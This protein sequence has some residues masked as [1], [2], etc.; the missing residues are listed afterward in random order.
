MNLSKKI[1]VAFGIGIA[2]VAAASGALTVKKGTLVTI[3]ATIDV[4]A[5]P[6]KV[7]SAITSLDGFAALTGFKA[8]GGAAFRK[9]GD[10]APA[11]AW[12]DKGRLVVTELVPEKELRVSF[13]PAQ[14]HYLCQKRIVLSPS[15]GGTR[16]EY[17]D[18]YTDDQPNAEQTAQQVV[19]ETEKSI[20]AFKRMVEK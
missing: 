2:C 3:P 9:I 19:A 8:T 15:A 7:W 14:G 16:I 6:A 11:T 18:R 20:D 1:A 4:K 5:P 10:S 17:W 13:E 12:E